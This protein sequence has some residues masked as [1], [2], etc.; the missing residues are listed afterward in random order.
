MTTSNPDA[1]KQAFPHVIKVADEPVRSVITIARAAKLGQNLADYFHLVNAS[2]DRHEGGSGL[3]KWDVS[4]RHPFAR[5]SDGSRAFLAVFELK[6]LELKF[7]GSWQQNWVGLLTRTQFYVPGQDDPFAGAVNN[8]AYPGENLGYP[9]LPPDVNVMRLPMEVEVSL[10]YAV[11]D[12]EEW[13]QGLLGNT[14][15]V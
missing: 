15:T 8:T 1:I 6:G 11:D 5:D 10:H 9:Y 14:G 3:T 13:L 7:A 4:L 2:L 12:G